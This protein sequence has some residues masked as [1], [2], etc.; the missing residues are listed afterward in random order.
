MSHG[1]LWTK[2]KRAFVRHYMADPERN[3]AEAARKA[4]YEASSSKQKGYALLNWPEHKL[5]QDA[6][7]EA[8]STA[9]SALALT[10][11]SVLQNI[12]RTYEFNKDDPS[13]GNQVVALKSLE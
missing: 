10:A 2:R 1:S 6:I 3:A 9:Q 8:N 5:V 11:T 13:A 4:G 7:A 12:I